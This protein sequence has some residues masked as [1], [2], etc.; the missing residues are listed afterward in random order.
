M[1][2][3]LPIEGKFFALRRTSGLRSAQPGTVMANQVASRPSHR[4]S[5]MTTAA[6]ALVLAFGIVQSGQA[7]S[8]DHTSK[9]AASSVYRLGPFDQIRLKIVAWRPSQAQ[10]FEWQAVNGDY[11]IDASGRIS[12]P[13]VGEVQAADETTIELAKRISER[14]QDR[15]NMAQRPDA[16]VEIIKYR[17]FYI[18]GDVAT[19]GEYPYRPGMTVIQAMAIA[20]GLPRSHAIDVHEIERQIVG[21]TGEL[22]E[23]ASE[24]TALLA[25]EARLAAELEGSDEVTFP[26]SLTEQGGKAAASAMK[27]ERLL[28]KTRKNAL[29]IS[30]KS[31]QQMKNYLT[32]EVA[33]INAQ[34]EQQNKLLALAQQDK[35]EVDQKQKHGL[36][37]EQRYLTAQRE[38][39]TAESDS[40]R[41]Q[42]RLKAALEDLNKAQT[43]FLEVNSKF[44]EGVATDLNTT[45]ARLEQITAKMA[46]DRGLVAQSDKIAPIWIGAQLSFSIIRRSGQR[47][48]EFPATE[49]TLVSPGDTIKVK[50]CGSGQDDLTAAIS[51]QLSQHEEARSQ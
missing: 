39:A 40:L 36:V 22:N 15:I 10:V 26:T 45:K 1:H 16:S 29:E 50:C 44:K 9:S 25:R 35:Q 43:S 11:T 49:T 2:K 23:L 14:L 38:A 17:P 37:T 13:L 20:G 8:P 12:L 19:S 5:L 30:A 46:T 3:P 48:D 27:Q 47:F 6:L 28:F 33:S 4:L 34:I 32:G 42:S 24:R 21:W 31:L 7:Q 18:V 51:R 41:L